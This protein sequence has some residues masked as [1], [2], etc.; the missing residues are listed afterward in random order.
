MCRQFQL[1][2]ILS[3]FKRTR[4]YVA[5]SWLQRGHVWRMAAI[6]VQQA[7]F[8]M[9]QQTLVCRGV[10]CSHFNLCDLLVGLR[11]DWSSM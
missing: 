11:P 3:S 6:G 4:V 5:L 8:P 1:C 9:A 2:R 10:E 7:S